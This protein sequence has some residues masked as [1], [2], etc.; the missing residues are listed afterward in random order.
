M[1]IVV[2]LGG[3][4]LLRKGEKGTYQEQFRNAMQ[5]AKF[6]A[7]I[8]EKGYEL[9]I[10]HGNGPQAG[11]IALQNEI[12]KDTVPPMP[13]DVVNAETQALIGYMLQQSLINEL[14]RRN[15]SKNIV[16]IVT[17]VVVRK[18]DPAFNNPTKFIGPYYYDENVVKKI[19]KEKGWIIKKD[20]RGGWRR[21]VPSPE[22]ID[23][24]EKDV[25]VNMLR[26]GI[27]CIT[28]GGGGIPVILEE[29]KY[30]GVEAVID[31]DLASSL[32]ARIIKADALMILTDVEY[33]Y[34]NFGKP[35]AKPIKEITLAE[36]EKYYEEGQ[37]PPGSMGPKILGAIK[38][39][40]SGG[41]RAMIGHLEK[42]MDVL[43]GKTG[44][45]IIR[46]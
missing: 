27:V 38:F 20:P 7:D 46:E 36:I 41:K 21:V 29:G 34:L 19:M 39:L 9:V 10:T 37:F 22:P 14:R 24:V 35:D 11:A 32:V 23:I 4:A 3:N 16:A 30:K 6:L 17:Q 45:Q 44:T 31:K 18:N 42:A 12:A 15:I 28:V 1:R 43:N 5:T 33:V 2:A 13:L 26:Q 40:R 8:I 25:I